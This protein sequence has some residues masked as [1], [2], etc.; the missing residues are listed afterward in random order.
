[1]RKFHLN[2]ERPIVELEK[3]LDELRQLPR[4]QE[5]SIK[6]QID[7]LEA[8]IEKLRQHIYSN[9]TPWQKVQIARHPERP[10]SSDYIEMLFSNFM[11]LHGDRLFG[12]DY[13]MITGFA[14][15]GH[16]KIAIIAEEKGKNVKE[17]VKRNFGMP[18]PEG[19]RK[20]LRIA[21][22]AEK[23]GLPILCFIDTSG[24]YPGIG[25]EERGQAAAIAN[26]LMEFSRLKCPILVTNIGEGGSGGALAIGVGDAL[27]MMENA[28][29]S[30]IAPEGCATILYGGK[31]NASEAAT[32]LKLTAHELKEMKIVDAIIPEPLGGAHAD[33]EEVASHLGR[34]LSGILD[35][36]EKES[37]DKLV[38][39][40]YKKIRNFGDYKVAKK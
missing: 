16:H 21:K 15:F 3:R 18:N 29:Y 1:M 22:L 38:E 19:Y 12:D 10:V 9:L 5:S 39:K 14:T 28:Y 31:D 2:F 24:A 32:S 13:A 35:K 4:A 26:N 27:L 8:E 40:R 30:V 20:A 34:H 36:L 37:I 17:K 33:P 7:Y 11:E 25:A 23:Y 6:D